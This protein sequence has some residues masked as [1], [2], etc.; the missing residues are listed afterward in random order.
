LASNDKA[1]NIWRDSISFGN[2]IK[3]LCKIVVSSTVVLGLVVGLS[4][5]ISGE[6]TMEIDLTLDFG[7]F[8]GIWWV[9]GLPVLSILVF[10][11]LSPLSFLVYRQLSKKRAEGAQ[12][13]DQ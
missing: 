8:D 3:Q 11:I 5:L 9:I 6:T 10:V 12:N 1:Q 2:Y 4:L 13:D 7:P